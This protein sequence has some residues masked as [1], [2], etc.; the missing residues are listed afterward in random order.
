MFGINN[1]FG[2]PQ[3]MQAARQMLAQKNMTAE[4]AVRSICK[5]RGID[6]DNLI[7]SISNGKENTN[8]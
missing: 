2:N 1:W 8:G 6:V 5:E 3:Q 4:E 7:K